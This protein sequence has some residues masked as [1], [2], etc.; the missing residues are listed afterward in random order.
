MTKRKAKTRGVVMMAFGDKARKEAEA[1]IA[2]LHE[3]MAQLPVVVVGDRKVAGATFVKWDGESPFDVDAPQNYRFK[4]GRVKPFLYWS[5]PFDHVLYLDSDTRVW[6]DLSPAFDLL[7]SFEM[8]PTYHPDPHR[9]VPAQNVSALYNKARAGW[10]HNRR[11]R[12]ATIRGWGDGELPYWNSGVIFFRR[13]KA[14]ERVMRAW[15][16]EWMRYQQWDEQLALMRATFAH[17]LKLSVLPV[18]WNAPHKDQARYIWHNYGRA[19]VRDNGCAGRA[20]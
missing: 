2:S 13:C 16:E 10:Y 19:V 1:S 5:A 8:L 3:H 20:T 15:H 6:D 14:V 12:E 7:T 9:R 11:E 18:G 4:A 17:P